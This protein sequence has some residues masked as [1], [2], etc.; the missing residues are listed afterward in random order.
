MMHIKYNNALKWTLE[1]DEI[2]ISKYYCGSLSA[3]AEQTVAAVVTVVVVVL[4][5]LPWFDKCVLVA[6]SMLQ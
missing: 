2:H 3:M 6:R 5:A 4:M 1:M